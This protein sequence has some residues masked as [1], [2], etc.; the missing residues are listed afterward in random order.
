M[1]SQNL[2]YQIKNEHF[3]IEGYDIS[4][5]VFTFENIY[6]LLDSKKEGNTFTSQSLSWGETEIVKSNFELTYGKNEVNNTLKASAKI[7]GNN[8]RCIKF[9]MLIL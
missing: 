8:I 9:K 2:S 5:E 3:N 7:D 6:S 4:V 1:Q